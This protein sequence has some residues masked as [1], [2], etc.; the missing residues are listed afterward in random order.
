MCHEELRQ[1]QSPQ[2]LITSLLTTMTLF[3]MASLT[4]QSRLLFHVPWKMQIAWPTDLE[5]NP[6]HSPT[7]VTQVWVLHVDTVHANLN[8]VC[9][10][11]FWWFIHKDQVNGLNS[12][13]GS[14]K[15][16]NKSVLGLG[17]GNFLWRRKWQSTPIFLSGNAHGQSVGS[18]MSQTW[19]SD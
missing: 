18:Q 7:W 8:L 6:S 19:L 4:I 13:D 15:K 17:I 12:T 10:P 14:A 5:G 16:E 11:V 1:T 3:P 9:C 2:L